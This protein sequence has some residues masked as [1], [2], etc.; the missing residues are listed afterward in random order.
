MTG[1]QAPT[2]VGAN[3]PGKF[4]PRVLSLWD[5]F[6]RREVHDVFEPD[7]T[8]TPQAGTWGLQGIIRLKESPEDFV[9][10]V[11]F[12]KSQGDHTFD[13]H[14]TEDGVLTWQS[15]PSQH[16]KT[17]T[18]ATLITHDDMTNVIHLFLRTRSDLPYTYF[19]KLGY[20]E[21]DRTRERPVHF[22][23]QLMDWPAPDAVLA[24]LNIVPSPPA[25][26]APAPAPPSKNQLIQTPPPVVAQQPASGGAG[27]SAQPVLPGQDAKNRALGLAGELLVL[28]NE[29]DNL[30][31]AG[32][33]DLAAKVVHVAVVEGDRA[34]YDIRSYREDG[35]VRH[36][37]VKTTA[38][39]STNAFYIS[40]SEV[41]FS[42]DHPKT[43]VLLRVFGYEAATN[44]ANFY[45]IVGSVGNAF[46]L[47]PS[48]YRARLLPAAPV[49]ADAVT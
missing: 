25:T 8:F 41:S 39:P 19:G 2:P 28:H 29:R 36:I 27:G 40:P 43:Y 9:F 17:P 10:F 48:E 5:T 15:Q 12:G 14:I 20:L 37:E 4:A 11:T 47:T 6:T 24:S 22:R 3:T 7:T 42:D 44:S 30:V 13:E 34:G 18:I 1:S 16:L 32:R 38:G 33:A 31:A 21:H 26:P 46:N 35:T 49:A 45:E 23:W